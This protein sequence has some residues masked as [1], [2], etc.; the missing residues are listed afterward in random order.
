MERAVTITKKEFEEMSARTV[1]TLAT[2]SGG[3]DML[4]TLTGVLICAELE[5]VLFGEDKK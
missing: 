4:F 2:H 3:A 5:R 1:A